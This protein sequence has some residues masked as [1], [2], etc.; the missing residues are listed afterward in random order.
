MPKYITLLRGI[1]V[2]GQKK[3]KMEELSRLYESLG[4]RNV[5]TYI[6]SGNVLFDYKRAD[7]ASLKRKIESAIKQ[8][9]EFDVRV[10]VTT[11]T[12]LKHIVERNPFKD[13]KSCIT[14]LL[15]TPRKISRDEL[16][17]VKQ[18]TERFE[19]A[20]NV[21]Y[22]FCPSGYART[23]LSNNFIE[24]KLEVSSTTRGLKTLKKLLE[25]SQA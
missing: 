6:Q 10:L 4:F 16:N 25:L 12:K 23:K 21:V 13:E 19:I 7:V 22:L 14:L 15:E 2:S 24:R 20:N 1:N 5:K 17:A 9:F 18:E 3:M 8:Q 11:P